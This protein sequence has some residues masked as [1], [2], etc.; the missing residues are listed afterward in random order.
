MRMSAKGTAS[1]DIH[2]VRAPV[3]FLI[4]A[5]VRSCCTGEMGESAVWTMGR[6]ERGGG[7]GVREPRVGLGERELSG[8]VVLT[9]KEVRLEPWRKGAGEGGGV[10]IVRSAD[11]KRAWQWK[12]SDE[13]TEGLTGGES[14]QF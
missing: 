12:K 4:S 3:R 9:S 7:T 8:V 6:R 2:F 11:T 5:G 13:L 1:R 10:N 14:R